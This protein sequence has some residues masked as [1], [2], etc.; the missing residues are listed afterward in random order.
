MSAPLPRF[1]RRLVQ[2]LGVA[3]FLVALAPAPCALAGEPEA[4]VASLRE[5]LAKD[6]ARLIELLSQPARSD[7]QATVADSELREIAERMPRT[8][9]ALRSA[10]STDGPR[11]G[12]DDE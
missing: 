5:S 3:A 10:T 8:Q 6:R 2:L 1:L 4:D 11:T 9:E 7:A 12:I